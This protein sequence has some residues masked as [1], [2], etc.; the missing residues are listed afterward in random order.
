MD[1]K[2]GLSMVREMNVAG[3]P[4]SMFGYGGNTIGQHGGDVGNSDSYAPGDA[5]IPK[6]L[7]AVGNDPY[8][9]AK[10]CKKDKRGK[11]GKKSKKNTIPLYRRTFMEALSSESCDDEL[12]LN[13]VIYTTFS[14]YQRVITD[15]LDAYN[16]TYEINENSI[17][18]KGSDGYIQSILTNIRGI[19][20]EEPFNTGEI[21]AL[22]CE[23]DNSLDKLNNIP[24]GLAEHKTMDD[25]YNKYRNSFRGIEDFYIEFSERVNQG[26]RIEMEHTT[27]VNI[28]KE[29]ALDHLWEDLD[30]YD[31]LAKIEKKD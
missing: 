27:D 2:K 4:G 26:K 6:I 18:L 29:I 7:G 23:M 19:L 25:F 31:K 12:L 14:N 30:Y 20:T 5:R 9:Y 15:V 22:M 28:A 3:G 13:C 16:V 11:K 10:T 8:E 17:M 24:G 1:Y 21:L